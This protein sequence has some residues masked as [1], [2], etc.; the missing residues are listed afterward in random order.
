MF[1][2]GGP[3]HGFRDPPLPLDGPP[4]C[5]AVEQERGSVAIQGQHA[6]PIKGHIGLRILGE[7]GIANGSNPHG[8]RDRRA[9][10]LRDLGRLLVHDLASPSNRLVQHIFQVDDIA[11]ARG[12]RSAGQ[13]QQAKPDVL[14]LFGFYPAE[15]GDTGKELAEVELLPGVG[16]VDD[17]RGGPGV[18]SITKGR[19][20]RRGIEKGPVSL[21]N[22][23]GGVLEALAVLG[24]KGKDDRPLGLLRHPGFQ[25]G[26][27]DGSE[28]LSPRTSSKEMSM[29]E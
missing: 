10:G 29:R 12:H 24:C 21:A 13:R 5:V 14:Q 8:L 16:D 1:R 28:A 17:P 19:D 3:H 26:V 22:Q 27:H 2:S 6:F 23:E 20:V 11:L 9:L 25:E 18:Q 15:L 7:I 4:S